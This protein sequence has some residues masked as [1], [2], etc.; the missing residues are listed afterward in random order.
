MTT[1]V[2]ARCMPGT[3]LLRTLGLGAC[4]CSPISERS[5][6]QRPPTIG[7]SSPSL[8]TAPCLPERPETPWGSGMSRADTSRRN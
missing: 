5:L 6:C 4:S 8:P 1:T 2:Q 3:R 7:A